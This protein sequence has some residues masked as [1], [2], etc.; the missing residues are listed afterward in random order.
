MKRLLVPAMLLLLPGLALATAQFP[1]RL[2]YHGQEMFIFSEPLEYYFS[3]D[4]PRPRVFEEGGMCTAC[5]RGYVG[6]WKIEDGVLY[7]VALSDCG[8][9][10]EPR[11]IPLSVVFPDQAPPIK[12]EWYSGVLRVPQGEQ[13]MYVHMGYASQYERD[14]LIRVEKGRVV[15]EVVIDNTLKTKD[16]LYENMHKSPEEMLR[17]A[18]PQ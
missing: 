14:L 6:T 3:E 18:A 16:E 12:A 17:E 5:W 1:E 7:L 4:H 10:T 2:V 8:C 9:G 11:E 13:L 15:R